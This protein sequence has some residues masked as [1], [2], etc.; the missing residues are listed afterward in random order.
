MHDMTDGAPQ[1]AS[2]ATILASGGGGGHHEKVL[3]SDRV[4]V[5]TLNILAEWRRHSKHVGI[6]VFVGG[7]SCRRLPSYFDKTSS[8]FWWNRRQESPPT[9][10][11]YFTRAEYIAIEPP[12]SR[13]EA[14][15]SPATRA[16]TNCRHRSHSN[17]SRPA[18]DVQRRYLHAPGLRPTG[19]NDH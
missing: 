19:P 6:E 17:W 9:K 18:S 14:G 12:E 11:A 7:D 13:S 1:A 3:D 10:S 15:R 4:F 5:A 8:P 16:G 2:P